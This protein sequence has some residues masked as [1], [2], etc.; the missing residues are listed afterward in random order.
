MQSCV[1]ASHFLFTYLFKLVM[2]VL[3]LFGAHGHGTGHIIVYAY[4]PGWSLVSK[5]SVYVSFDAC[6]GLHSAFV[7][8]LFASNGVRLMLFDLLNSFDYFSFC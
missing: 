3:F 4:I 7:F 6:F 8:I 5:K 2:N 1:C